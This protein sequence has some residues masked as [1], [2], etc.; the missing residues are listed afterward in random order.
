LPLL[1]F[2]P[3]YNHAISRHHV[4][5]ADH[6]ARP[7]GTASSMSTAFCERIN[8]EAKHFVFSL[9]YVGDE[10]VAYFWAWT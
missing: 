10:F 8:N 5:A 6:F 2:Q 4:N 1:K 3:S 9:L 7:S